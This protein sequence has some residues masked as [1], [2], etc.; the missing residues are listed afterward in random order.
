MEKIVVPPS[1]VEF[2]ARGGYRRVCVQFADAEQLTQGP[3]IVSELEEAVRSSA[4][5]APEVYLIGDPVVTCCVDETAAAHVGATAAI[6]F[7]TSCLSWKSKIPTFYVFGH[8]PLNCSEFTSFCSRVEID[9]GCCLVFPD[10][11]YL[12]HCAEL[13]TALLSRPNFIVASLDNDIMSSSCTGATSDNSTDT[14]CTVWSFCGRRAVLPSPISQIVFIGSPESR[15]F[16]NLLLNFPMMNVTCYNPNTGTT[17]QAN[18]S[19]IVSR[20]YAIGIKALQSAST[21]ALVTS[22]A[23]STIEKAIAPL[24]SII[25]GAGKSCIVL[26]V[27]A[28]NEYK[29]A[30]F[31]D[32]DVFVVLSCTFNTVRNQANQFHKPLITP[33]E[34]CVCLNS[35]NWTGDYTTNLTRVLQYL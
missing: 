17:N 30:N 2:V 3:R 8:S 34:L 19:R 10:A 31:P 23:N 1:A 9:S 25:E 12:H 29:L 5:F 33:Y 28:I 24:R 4:G 20:R 26:S 14:S 16:E 21:V 27:G 35:I 18:G 15:T 11:P 13:K 6:L 22:P 7:G 32:V